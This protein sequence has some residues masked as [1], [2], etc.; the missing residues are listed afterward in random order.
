MMRR[1]QRPLAIILVFCLAIG[2][3]F[4]RAPDALLTPQ[5]WA[6]D[7][8][9]FWLEQYQHGFLA[10]LFQIYAGY[11]HAMPRLIAA[12]ASPLPYSMHPAAF[13]AAAGLV[14]RRGPQSANPLIWVPGG[15]W[16]SIPGKPV[17]W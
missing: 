10:S 2:L 7:A 3:L 13:V 8:N 4:V 14:R 1:M 11:V 17:C 5:F 12:I 16:L 15:S 9:H 6:E